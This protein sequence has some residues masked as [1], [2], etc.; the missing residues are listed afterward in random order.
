MRVPRA[1]F[2]Q[3]LLLKGD[4]FATSFFQ[5]CKSPLGAANTTRRRSLQTIGVT[6]SN[7][8]CDYDE[9]GLDS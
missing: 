2:A 4:F 1:F 5:A 3:S 9:N 6:V 8:D 7:P